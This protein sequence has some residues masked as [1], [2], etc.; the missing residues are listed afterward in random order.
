MHLKF[1]FGMHTS[2]QINSVAIQS[3][4][5]IQLRYFYFCFYYLLLLVI[6]SIFMLS[7]CIRT[8]GQPGQGPPAL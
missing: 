2:A 3:I 4:F 5:S 6:L 7:F 1:C 8:I